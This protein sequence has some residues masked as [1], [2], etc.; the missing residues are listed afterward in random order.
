MISARSI[1]AACLLLAATIPS[2][3]QRRKE[4]APPPADQEV[5]VSSRPYVPGL[6]PTD[7]L[8]VP[9]SVAVRDARGRAVPGLKA[10]D[11]QVLDQGKESAIVGVSQVMGA[12]GE[13]AKS[14]RYIALCFDDYLSSPGQLQRAKSIGT[15]F[16]QEGLAPGDMASISTTYFKRM[17]DFTSDKQKLVGAI[18]RIVPQATPSM[19]TTQ[20]TRPGQMPGTQRAGAAVAAGSDAAFAGEIV[21]RTFLDLISAYDKE[22]SRIQGSRAILLLSP[23]FQGMPDREQDLVITQT[24]AAGVVIN[25]LDSKS[26][27]REV[28]SVNGDPAYQLPPQSYNFETAGLGIESAMAEFAHG[29]GGLFFHH[30][31]DPFSHGY[32]ELGDVPEMRY[33]L[34]VHPD[35]SETKFHR[36]KVQ[37]KASGPNVVEARTGYFPPKGGSAEKADTQPDTRAKLDAQVLSTK[38]VSDF[39]FTVGISYS[40]LPS[41]KTGIAVMLH[42]DLKDLPFAM[43]NDRHTQKLTLVAAILD[44]NGNLISAKEGLM[45]FALTDGKFNAVKA[46]GVGAALNLEAPSG[47]YRLCTVGQE[48]GGKMASTLNAIQVP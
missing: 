21:S 8:L 32:H 45:E 26:S 46:E 17:T 9:V 41:G 37:L 31:G 34:A 23:G 3:A 39:P 28:N 13:A 5:R 11:F 38:P 2:S 14:P 44:E 35:E 4:Q 6:P 7:V 36:L 22:L 15:R 24:V 47:A 30:D 16:I 29:T 20:I 40:K 43:R 42:A 33:V 48:M 12:G 10:A 1:T 27:F 18:E 19:T 25:A